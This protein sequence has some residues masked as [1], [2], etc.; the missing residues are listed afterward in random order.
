M[1]TVPPSRVSQPA[2][3]GSCGIPS[4]IRKRRCG[5][6]V[7]I[8]YRPVHECTLTDDVEYNKPKKRVY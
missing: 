7:K 2:M 6:T 5:G 8:D 3:P 1:I 4:P